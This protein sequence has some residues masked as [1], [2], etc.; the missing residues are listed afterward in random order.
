MNKMNPQP[1]LKSKIDNHPS[2]GSHNRND[3]HHDHYLK[4][5]EP[6]FSMVV[7]LMEKMNYARIRNFRFSAND[8][9]VMV[10]LI[11]IRT[12]N[13]GIDTDRYRFWFVDLQHT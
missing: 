2:Y 10:F 11:D 3:C 4:E 9:V 8:I 13:G 7:G 6:I 1:H 5:D 12:T